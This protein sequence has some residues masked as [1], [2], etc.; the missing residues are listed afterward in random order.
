M[1]RLNGLGRLTDGHCSFVCSKPL[2]FQQSRSSDR[3]LPVAAAI[4]ASAQITAEDMPDVAAC[5]PDV[6]PDITFAA[7]AGSVCD[8]E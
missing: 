6:M 1:T 3:K 5:M 4:A 7:S 2:Q 8:R